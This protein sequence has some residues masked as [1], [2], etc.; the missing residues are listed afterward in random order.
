MVLYQAFAFM[1]VQVS[2]CWDL[3]GEE[4]KPLGRCLAAC[5]RCWLGY[6]EDLNLDQVEGA[7]G[8]VIWI[9][10]HLKTS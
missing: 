1:G 5:E 6:D 4:L 9:A 2:L 7:T 3:V 8:N 10:G